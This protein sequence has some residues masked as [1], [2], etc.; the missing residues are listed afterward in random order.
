M[1]NYIHILY[2]LNTLYTIHSTLY[3]L[4]P[5]LYTL[6]STLYILH[7]TLY[8]T[9]HSALQNVFVVRLLNPDYICKKSKSH[10]IRQFS[11][12]KPAKD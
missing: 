7:S 8:T 11:S 5:T 3:I 6:H 4:H 12:W 9:L 1:H 2:K 10:V